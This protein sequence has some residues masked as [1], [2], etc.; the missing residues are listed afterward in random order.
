MRKGAFDFIEKENLSSV[1]PA[2]IEKM[3]EYR[4]TRQERE[5]LGEENRYL[6]EEIGGRFNF[7]EIVGRSSQIE[8]ILT[9][10]QKVAVTDS[11]VLVWGPLG[12]DSAGRCDSAGRSDIELF[13]TGGCAQRLSIGGGRCVSV[14][15]DGN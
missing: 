8:A 12:A 7:G 13:P 6:R 14:K 2:K 3:L 9:T 10:V 4:A 5:R 1:L 15:C 11:S